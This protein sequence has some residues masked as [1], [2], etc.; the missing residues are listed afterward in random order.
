ML[1]SFVN[2]RIGWWNITENNAIQVLVAFIVFILF[3]ISWFYVIDLSKELD[4][5]K[6]EFNEN[7]KVCENKDTPASKI[8]ET[9]DS[10]SYNMKK[11]LMKWNEFF[12]I[13]ILLLAVS[14]GITR[15]TVTYAVG[16]VTL[17]SVNIFHWKMNSL[18]LLHIILGSFAYLTTTV[19]VKLKIITGTTILFFTYILG[20]CTS[21]SLMAIF[22]LPK[23]IEFPNVWSQ[24]AYG[25]S[26]LFLKCFVFFQAQSSGKFLMFNTTSYDN[27]NS[28]DGFRS[29]IGNIFRFFAKLSLFSF[30]QH[31][32]YFIPPLYLFTFVITAWLIFRREE[33]LNISKI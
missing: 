26:V 11:D 13:D 29:L 32:E 14:Y 30:F 4:L 31:T 17:I 9:E 19:L 33:H 24:A 16:Y 27:A 22:L 18:A 2:I 20:L 23:A 7:M 21:M 15:A 3:C 12:Q 28:V 6:L 25:G 8:D 10:K 5:I 1:L